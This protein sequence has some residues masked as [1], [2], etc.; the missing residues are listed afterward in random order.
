[1]SL[2]SAT[3]KV[4]KDESFEIV[5]L[6]ADDAGRRAVAALTANGGIRPMV[7]QQRENPLDDRSK[8]V[9]QE[10]VSDGVC[11]FAWVELKPANNAFCKWLVKKGYASKLSGPGVSIW[12]HDYNQSMQ[13]KAAYARAFCQV[14]KSQA[15][16]LRLKSVY[17][18]SRMD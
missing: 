11:G 4:Q 12:V 14:I 3:S 6:M 5:Y 15:Q 18:G 2:S 13:K 8:V 7:V 1:M 9:Y 10:T 17:S 16:D